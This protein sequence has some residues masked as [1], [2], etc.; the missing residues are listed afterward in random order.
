M[1]VFEEKANEIGTA[2][3]FASDAYKI[4]KLKS[5]S[6]RAEYAVLGAIFG[7]FEL[8]LL[9]EYQSLNLPGVFK[10]IELLREG[11]FDISNKAIR[12]GLRAVSSITGLLGRWQILQRNPLV[13]CDTGHNADGINLIVDQLKNYEF[14]RLFFVLGTVNDK[15]LD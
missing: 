5:K 1:R 10:M 15:K 4:E 11:G 13:I 6:S 2:L 14:Q 7:T 12:D 9:G 8:D 3:Y